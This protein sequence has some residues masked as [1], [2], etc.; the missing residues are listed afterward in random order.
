[1]SLFGTT[2]RFFFFSSL[3]LSFMNNGIACAK[4][5]IMQWKRRAWLTRQT[6]IG[7]AIVAAAV[8]NKISI[9]GPTPFQPVEKSLENKVVVEMGTRPAAPLL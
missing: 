8:A 2:P 5:P 1:M 3:F 6:A 9:R 7:G 4:F